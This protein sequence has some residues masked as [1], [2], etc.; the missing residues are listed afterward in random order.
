MRVATHE[1]VNATINRL[2]IGVTAKTGDLVLVREASSIRIRE[3]CGN[4]LHHEKYTGPWTT[5][6]VFVTGLSVKVE[7]RGRRARKR[8]AATSAL[9]PFTVRRPD[10]RHLMEDKFAQYAWEASYN[11]PRRTPTARPPPPSTYTRRT[12]GNDHSHRVPPLGA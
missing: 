10:L 11:D 9:K 5:K 2:T 12:P 1:R 4:K 6:R 7:L 8:T 3:G